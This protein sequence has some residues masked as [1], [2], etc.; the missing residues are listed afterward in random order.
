MR[1][2]RVMAAVLFGG[3]VAAGITLTADAHARVFR[4]RMAGLFCQV[5][6]GIDDFFG[7]NAATGYDTTNSG[8]WVWV[9]GGCPLP[10][11][12]YGVEPNDTRGRLLHSV[13]VWYYHQDTAYV[14]V[15]LGLDDYDSLSYCE[16][17]VATAT[18]ESGGFSDKTVY[19][20]SLCDGCGST[21]WTLF[22]N[23]KMGAQDQMI[24]NV[25]AYSV[26][27]VE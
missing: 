9:G 13:R 1:V 27:S 24:S 22:L 15:T 14:E 11:G 17:D 2:H 6:S 8:H 5:S 18:N 23:V 7:V 21:S 10:Q 3:A 16:C 25:E 26:Y 12:P 20:T 4:A 19:Y